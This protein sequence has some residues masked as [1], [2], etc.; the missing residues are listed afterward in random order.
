MS[1]P[2]SKETDLLNKLRRGDHMAFEKLFETHYYQLTGH[3]MAILKSRDLVKE[4][5]QDTFTAL[6]EHRSRINP[7]KP[8]K[9]YIYRIAANLAFNLLKK[10]AYDRKYRA[11]LYPVI[12]AGYDH[13]ESHILHKEYREILEDMLRMMPEKQRET[14][15][16]CKIEGKR[17]EEA[18][19]IL[20]VSLHTIH[21]Q[22]KRANKF[23]RNY[24]QNHP[25]ILGTILL[26]SAHDITLV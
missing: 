22:M 26:L 25:G 1:T 4:I 10:A 24:L 17:Y 11:H 20:G 19:S 12:T 13:I 15:V 18:A 23:L 21:T 16:L 14:F 8:L 9:P 3:L 5:M 2:I 7:D 6:W